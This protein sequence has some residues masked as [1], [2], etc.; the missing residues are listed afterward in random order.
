MADRLGDVAGARPP[1]RRS[2]PRLPTIRRP[3]G[4][5]RQR[6]HPAH[7]PAG[8]F[9]IFLSATGFFKSPRSSGCRARILSRGRAPGSM[10]GFAGPDAHRLV[11]LEKGTHA[12]FR[13]GGGSTAFF[14]THGFKRY[15]ESQEDRLLHDQT[16]MSDIAKI[17]YLEVIDSTLFDRRGGGG[18]AFTLSVPLILLA[19]DRRH[20]CAGSLP[21]TTSRRSSATFYLQERCDVLGAGAR[22]RHAGSWLRH[23]HPEWVAPL[24]PS[25]SSGTFSGS[26]GSTPSR[27]PLTAHLVPESKRVRFC[28]PFRK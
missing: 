22:V 19:T 25:S 9:F 26:P 3:E 28:R 11:C 20:R 15:A 18:F 16:S 24:A 8:V 5:S 6:P 12:G 4:H 13:R 14:I 2:P 27:S 21:S 7:R 1:G 23:T 17:L 10:R